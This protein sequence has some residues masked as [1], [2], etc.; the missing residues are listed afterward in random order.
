MG[1][2]ASSHLQTPL[3]GSLSK[4]KKWQSGTF[5]SIQDTFTSLESELNKPTDC[6]DLSTPRST[7]LEVKRLRKLIYSES[8]KTKADPS[9]QNKKHSRISVV[10]SELLY[11]GQGEGNEGKKQDDGSNE[12]YNEHRERRR[13]KRIIRRK[14]STDNTAAN[15]LTVMKDHRLSNIKST[16]PDTSTDHL[17]EEEAHAHVQNFIHTDYSD[18]EVAVL[19]SD[20]RGFTS[21]TRKYGIVHFASI[22]VRMRQLVLPIFAKYKA[23]NIA[24]EAD[25]FITVFPDAC[26][27]VSAALEMQQILLKYN[28]SLSEDR[29][30]YKVRLNGIGKCTCMRRFYINF[31]FSIFD[32]SLLFFFFLICLFFLN[33]S[34]FL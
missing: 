20:L 1:A 14:L 22:I 28:A 5:N 31:D 23:L 3:S 4:H 25:N 13:M 33:C 19:V 27:A 24:T 16:D 6:S 9:H 34:F 30:H 26:S 18:R 29:Q 15:I 17:V 10:S 21:T 2:G 8:K 11:G 12:E 32:R 7:K